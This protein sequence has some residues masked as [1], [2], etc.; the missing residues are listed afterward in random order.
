[1]SFIFLTSVNTYGFKNQTMKNKYLSGIARYIDKHV[2]SQLKYK[3]LA[4]TQNTPI[5]NDTTRVVLCS[6]TAKNLI[7]FIGIISLFSGWFCIFQA[8]TYLWFQ[9]NGNNRI[10]VIR[11][12]NIKKK[13]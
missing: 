8:L 6:K 3:K 13:H 7:K 9:L 11:G 12:F 2:S 1:M 5:S 4:L 10:F